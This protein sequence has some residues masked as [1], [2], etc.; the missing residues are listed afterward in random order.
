MVSNDTAPVKFCWMIA[1]ASFGSICALSSSPSA[2]K[3]STTPS[4]PPSSLRRALDE[5]RVRGEIGGVEFARQCW[6]SGTHLN[7]VGDV[8]GLG[9][10]A[11]R[12]IEVSADRGE[13][14]RE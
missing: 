10:I 6:N 1:S 9:F 7:V 2:P 8:A 12:Y 4:R 11:R 5:F 13:L 3:Q 14:D